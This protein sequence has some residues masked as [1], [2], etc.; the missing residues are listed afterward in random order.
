[1]TMNTNK[2]TMVYNKLVRDKVPD[3]IRESGKVCKIEKAFGNVYLAY[4]FKKLAEE[5]E[6]L[7][8]ARSVEE[9]AEVRE[10]INAIQTYLRIDEHVLLECMK[11][12]RESNG[13]FGQGYILKEVASN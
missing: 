7:E 6:E 9:L 12:K 5:S 11:S 10:V 3:I 8:E 2:T 4:L 13:G 1:M